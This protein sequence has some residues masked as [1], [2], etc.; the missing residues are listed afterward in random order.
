MS[1][2]QRQLIELPALAAVSKAHP[3]RWQPLN[4]WGACPRGKVAL[5]AWL[6]DEGSLTAQLMRLSQGSLRVRILRQAWDLPTRLELQALGIK[7]PVR[8][9]VRE[10]ILQGNGQDWVYARSLLPSTSL[11]G[12]LRHLRKQDTSPLGAYLFR[13]AQLQRSPMEVVRLAPGSGYTPGYLTQGQSL[14][15][16]RSVFRLHNQPLLVSEVFLPAFAA[17]LAQLPPLNSSK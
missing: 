5:R 11:T 1:Q 14:W 12:R 13:Q 4:R 8:T 15:A 10:V 17:Y 6:G 7:Q 3:L 16:R 2:A 9:L